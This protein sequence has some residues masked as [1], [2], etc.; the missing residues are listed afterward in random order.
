MVAA[1]P[2]ENCRYYKTWLATYNVDLYKLISTSTQSQNL[3]AAAEAYP[4]KI[5][6]DVTSLRLWQ[7]PSKSVQ[8]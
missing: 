8:K 6:F 4:L 1:Q 3:E 2:P 7:R 5:L